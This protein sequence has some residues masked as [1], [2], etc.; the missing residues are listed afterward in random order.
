MDL[1]LIRPLPFLP[2][3]RIV[4]AV[5]RRLEDRRTGRALDRLDD[6]L[7]ADIGLPPQEIGLPDI[8]Q[9]MLMSM[10]TWR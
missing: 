8:G 6:H 3:G 9:A 4:Q 10:G 7:R 2:S 1:S 5:R